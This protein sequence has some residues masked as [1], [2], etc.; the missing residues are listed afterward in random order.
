MESTGPLQLHPSAS[1]FLPC[2]FG[3]HP[4][5]GCSHRVVG[6]D[7]SGNTPVGLVA[8][9]HRRDRFAHR[10][11]VGVDHQQCGWKEVSGELDLHACVCG[12]THHWAGEA[13][14]QQ[15]AVRTT[16]GQEEAQAARGRERFY[17][18][19]QGAKLDT[20]FSAPKRA[21]AEEA[22]NE[23]T[24]ATQAF[25]FGTGAIVKPLEAAQD[26][27]MTRASQVTKVNSGES[28]GAALETSTTGAKR[29]P[30]RAVAPPSTMA[31]A[32]TA[33][34]GQVKSRMIETEAM[35]SRTN[36]KS[37]KRS[38]RSVVVP[39]QREPPPL[40]GIPKDPPRPCR[41]VALLVRL[42]L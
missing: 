29:R 11:R 12:T 15:L 18:V 27:R 14:V 7:Q 30:D 5:T 8:R 41:P 1:L 39:R 28:N 3:L 24:T 19:A 6:N 32:K 33:E 31:N 25:S 36:S 10:D 13:A 2:R 37:S 34:G 4:S 23:A 35:V 22:C 21:T 38:R 20:G 9:T 26:G 17:R 42:Y 16:A 40:D